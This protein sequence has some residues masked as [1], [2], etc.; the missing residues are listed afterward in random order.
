MHSKHWFDV[1]CHPRVSYNAQKWSGQSWNSNSSVRSFLVRIPLLFRSENTKCSRSLISS[2]E[3]LI[4]TRHCVLMFHGD[5]PDRC[6]TRASPLTCQTREWNSFPEVVRLQ[7]LF[8]ETKSEP[9]WVTLRSHHEMVSS[10]SFW[11][12]TTSGN[13][14]HSRVWQVRGLAHQSHGSGPSPWSI[15]TPWYVWMS[16]SMELIREREHFVVL[17][18]FLNEITR[19]SW[20]SCRQARKDSLMD[21]WAVF[22]VV[23][24]P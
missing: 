18:S 3:E 4:Q 11:S 14:F 23:G 15:R 20:L 10:K 2:I 16:S 12:R 13:E 8:D 22:W 21:L 9:V 19:E 7:K 5:V 6:D 17:V 24:C 1:T